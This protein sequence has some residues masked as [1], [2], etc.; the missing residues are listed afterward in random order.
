MKLA[1]METKE[2]TDFRKIIFLEFF[3]KNLMKFILKFSISCLFSI[4]NEKE[5]TF[6]GY[7]YGLFRFAAWQ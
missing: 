2:N 5:H 1:D 3:E 7:F 6:L 4:N